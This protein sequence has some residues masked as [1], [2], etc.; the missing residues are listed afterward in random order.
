MNRLHI[1]LLITAL[2]CLS[3]ATR[4]KQPLV[5]PSDTFNPAQILPAP[6]TDDSTE[7][8][9]ERARQIPAPTQ[10]QGTAWIVTR[11]NGDAIQDNAPTLTIENNRA[12]GNSS[13]N[14]Y[15]G[16]VTIGDNNSLHF[17]PTAST[18]MACPG[19]A[20]RQEMAYVAALEH[21]SSY[22]LNQGNLILLDKDFNKVIEYRAKE[23]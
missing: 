3:S 21:V 8:A 6:P 7:A 23:Q 14:R 9:A 20:D 11:I 15:T 1:T 13:C 2:T 19:D 12:F 10:L 22:H 18:R 4:A 5:L 16:K 17:G